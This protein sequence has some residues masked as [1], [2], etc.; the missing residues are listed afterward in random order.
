MTTEPKIQGWRVTRLSGAGYGKA[1]R[2]IDA[3]I[4]NVD[5]QDFWAPGARE[6]HSIEPLIQLSDYQRLQADHE[7]L[8][9]ERAADKARI[10][11]LEEQRD[12]FT[13]HKIASR[14][15]IGIPASVGVCEPVEGF[16]ERPQDLAPAMREM[17]L[18]IEADKARIAEL[19]S[20][21]GDLLAIV[22]DSTGVAGYHL[23]GAVAE[24]GD[25][26]EVS[27]ASAVL[28]KKAKEGE[29]NHVEE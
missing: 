25:F 15:C 26:D 29:G 14:Q 20:A 17:A 6:R 28:A 23:N 7:R 4:Y 21:L 2:L 19:E 3:E 24:W 18:I 22:S 10:K 1:R 9:A 5:S 16:A 13:M 8:Q 12:A 11:L 27:A